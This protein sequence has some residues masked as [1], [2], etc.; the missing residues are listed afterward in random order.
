MLPIGAIEPHGTHLPLGT[1][2][3]VAVM[4]VRPDLVGEEAYKEGEVVVHSRGFRAYP[5][6]KTV[7][8]YS[9]EGGVAFSRKR[10]E[11]YLERS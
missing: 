6:H 5:L 1:D 11:E 10:A 7:I 4:A 2:A 8:N 9:E 3:T